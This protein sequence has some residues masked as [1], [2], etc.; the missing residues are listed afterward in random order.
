MQQNPIYTIQKEMISV[1]VRPTRKAK[2]RFKMNNQ[3]NI[4]FLFRSVVWFVLSL[5]FN[6]YVYKYEFIQC[7]LLSLSSSLCIK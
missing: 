7:F 2:K 4:C 3:Q 1:Y 6:V 5:D